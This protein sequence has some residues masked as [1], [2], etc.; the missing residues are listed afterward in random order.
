MRRPITLAAFTGALGLSA[1]SVSACPSDGE[2]Q[3]MMSTLPGGGIFGGGVVCV[4]PLLLGTIKGWFARA[5]GLEH[6]WPRSVLACYVSTLALTVGFILCFAIPPLFIFW[7]PG[8]VILSSLIEHQFLNRY[9]DR[10]Q[11]APVEVNDGWM[12]EKHTLSYARPMQKSIDGLKFRW[13]FAGNLVTAIGMPMLIPLMAMLGLL[14]RSHHQWANHHVA[15]ATIGALVIGAVGLIWAILASQ[16]NRPENALSCEPIGMEV[17]IA[18]AST[19][20]K[21]QSHP[22]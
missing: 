3:M 5:G 22:A 13:I 7:L 8:S 14:T 10:I 11:I 15:I 19:D 9:V 2:M 18:L 17:G 12:D 20:S 21:I 6:A 16:R 1:S 4:I